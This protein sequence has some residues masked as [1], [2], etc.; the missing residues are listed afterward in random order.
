MVV[1]LTKGYSQIPITFN[2]G[3]GSGQMGSTV[4][5]DVTF[6]DFMKVTSTQFEIRFDPNVL[7]L[8]TPIDVSTSVLNEG[9][10][11]GL[12][13]NNFNDVDAANGFLAVVWIDVATTGKTFDDDEIFFTLC[14][15]LIGEPCET[16]EI[17]ITESGKITFEFI[18]IDCVTGEE[19][20]FPPVVNSGEITIDPAG[21]AISSAFCSSDDAS[22]S[23]SITFSGSGGTGPYDWELTGGASGSGLNDCEMITVDDLAPGQYTLTLIDANNTVINEIITISTNSD[24]PFVLTLDGT[25]PT[26]FDRLNGS[27]GVIDIEGGEAPFEYAWSNMEFNEDTITQLGMGEYTLT[28]TDVNGCTTSSSATIEVDTLTVNFDVISDPSCDG[29]SNGIVSLSAEGGTPFPGNGYDFE[30]NGV[31]ST[32]YFASNFM[33]IDIFTPANLPSGCFEI[34]ASDNA[35]FPCF[36]D[37]VEFCIEAGSFSTLDIQV[38]DISCFGACDGAVVITADDMGNYSFMVTDPD[39]NAQTGMNTNL[40]FDADNLC[41]GI[42]EVTVNDVNAGCSIDTTFTILEPELLVL[43]VIDSLGP[44]CGG[45]DGMISFGAAGGTEPYTF[46]WNDGFDEAERINMGGGN[47]SVTLSDA[48]GCRDSIDFTFSDGGNIG[49]NVLVCNAITCGGV[50]DGSVCASVSAAGNYSFNWEDSE[51]NDIGSGGQ[52]DNLAAGF[53]FVTATDGMCTDTDTVFLAPGQ[54]PDVSIAFTPPTCPDVSDGMLVATLTSGTSPA[55][56]EWTEPPSTNVLSAGAVLSDGVGTYNLN[57][58]DALG[59]ELDT[60]VEIT[61]PTNTIQVDITNIIENT[62]FGECEGVATF[63]ASGGPDGNGNYVFFVS[64]ISTPIDPNGDMTTVSTLCGGENWVYAIDGICASDTFFF[65]VPDADPITLV[66]SGTIINPPS[67]AGG[68][69]GSITIEVQG[70]NDSSYDI[71]WINEGIAGPS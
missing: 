68:N 69:D 4:C 58:T 60:L 35:T 29:S 18:Q 13:I 28:I 66:E 51:G 1:S 64:N 50:A 52:I 45:G 30:I 34:V 47:Y 63:T 57:V 6:E 59:C 3:S 8:N 15:E 32:I 10:M 42:Y 41:P 55:T 12:S 31:G 17:T 11:A 39:G 61:P 16:S 22:N 14:F 26:C 20:D 44:G 40:A 9:G 36:S 7:R 49:L 2:V 53:Y 37:P 71:F 70:G 19:N 21:Y 5:V 33:P 48:N 62:C 38:T 54:T 24:F 25:N 65:T 56:F 23:G 27:V 67:C 43:S 46:E